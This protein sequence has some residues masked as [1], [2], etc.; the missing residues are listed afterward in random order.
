MNKKE[1][2]KLLKLAMEEYD[3]NFDWVDYEE[4]RRDIIEGLIFWIEYRF[5]SLKRKLQKQNKKEK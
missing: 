2:I 3:G 5:N 1:I 4:A